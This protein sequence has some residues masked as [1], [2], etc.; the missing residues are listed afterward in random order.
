M[1][2]QKQLSGDLEDQEY[3]IDIRLESGFKDFRNSSVNI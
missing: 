2:R 3:L 1:P